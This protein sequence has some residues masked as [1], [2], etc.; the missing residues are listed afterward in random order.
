M[1]DT[2]QK[3]FRKEKPELLIGDRAYDSDPLDERL[4]QPGIQLIAPS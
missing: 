2:L 1:E 3:R 4:Q